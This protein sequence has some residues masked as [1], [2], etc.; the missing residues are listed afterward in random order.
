MQLR[1]TLVQSFLHWVPFGVLTLML[2]GGIY[3]VVQQNYRSNANDPQI[4]IATDARNALQGGASPHSLVPTTHIDL[5]QSLAPYL[6]IYDTNGQPVVSSAT[7]HGQLP[8]PPPSGVFANAK[9][10]DMDILTWEP[11]PGVRSAIVVLPYANGYILAGRSLTVVEDRENNL[12]VLVAALGILTL[13]ASYL[14]VFFTRLA[15]RF[16]MDSPSRQETSSATDR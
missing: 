3:A 7:L 4:Q 5:S 1:Q 8:P 2:C 9:T 12:V 13:I 11:A 10:S 6:I 16:L 15:V 14:A